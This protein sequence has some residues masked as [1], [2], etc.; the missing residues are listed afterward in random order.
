MSSPLATWVLQKPQRRIDVRLIQT[1]ASQGAALLHDPLTGQTLHL[2]TIEAYLW[3]LLDGRSSV[4]DILLNCQRRFAP[5]PVSAENL[6]RFLAQLLQLGL[7]RSTTHSLTSHSGRQRSTGLRRLNPLA[8]TWRGCNPDSLIRRLTPLTGWIFHP[9]WAFT[10]LLLWLITLGSLAHQSARLV[11]DLRLLPVRGPLVWG[12]LALTIVVI[13]ICHEFGHALAARRVGVPC[14]ELGVML[15]FGFPLMYCNVSEATL[16]P[17][18]RDRLTI[19]AAGIY[20]ELWLALLAAWIWL[21]TAPGI[22]QTLGLQVMLI[23]SVNTLLLNGNPLLRYDGY[24]VFSD[25]LGVHNLRPRAFAALRR[26]L[27]RIITGIETPQPQPLTAMET[28]G[29]LSYGMAATVYSWGLFFSLWLVAVH[30]LEP[31]GL[32]WLAQLAGG[33]ILLSWLGQ[34]VQRGLLGIV[35]APVAGTMPYPPSR[36]GWWRTGI[37]LILTLLGLVGCAWLPVQPAITATLEIVPTAPVPVLIDSSGTL[38]SPAE[39]PDGSWSLTVQLGETL[40]QL[41][42]LQLQRRYQEQLGES[43]R[44]A[45]RIQ[46]YRTRLGQEPQLA[47]PLAAIEQAFAAQQRQLELTDQLLQRCSIKAPATGLLIWRVPAIAGEPVAVESQPLNP[48][49]LA[50]RTFPVGTQLGEIMTSVR[51]GRLLLLQSELQELRPGQAVRMVVPE[52]PGTCWTG[53]IASIGTEPLAELPPQFSLDQ[54]M[55]L[56]REAGQ[57]SGRGEEPVYLVSVTWDNST[58]A[59]TPGQ[60]GTARIALAPIPLWKAVWRFLTR[61]FP[62]LGHS[63]HTAMIW[64]G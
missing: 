64:T 55:A 1:D 7:I 62:L 60:L 48:G 57:R 29:L 34:A 27:L 19:S 18:R 24:Y 30:W 20:V 41:E 15:L 58:R 38:N 56:R 44:L 53:V 26:G 28:L 63:S 46:S 40:L 22:L 10:L 25:L 35:T 17:R 45:A 50:G 61:T 51:E 42:N 11:S 39:V 33:A 4:S 14:R 16:L 49:M 52:V 23:C 31:V 47:A 59:L 6:S 21:V 32:S 9:V 37:G 43:Q 5:Q 36:P 13:K 12:W 2:G 54:R 8:I 3:Q